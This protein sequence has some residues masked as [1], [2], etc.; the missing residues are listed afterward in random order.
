MMKTS[1]QLRRFLLWILLLPCITFP[2]AAI[3]DSAGIYNPA[4]LKVANGEQIYTHIC[5][6]CHMPDG[7]GAEGA[8]RYPAFSGNPKLA[9]AAYMAVTVLYGRHDMPSFMISA[10][11]DEEERFMRSAEL[12]DEQ[13]AQVINYIRTHFG[14][15]YTGP[16]TAN[17]VAALHAGNH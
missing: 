1:A 14:N 17:D 13:I 7:K 2:G 5:Q 16:L 15:R 12:S 11:E 9:S 4:A 6:G 3:A 8:G 10:R